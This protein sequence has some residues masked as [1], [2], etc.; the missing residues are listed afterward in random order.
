MDAVAILMPKKYVIQ[1]IEK[2]NPIKNNGKSILLVNR[3]SLRPGSRKKINRAV[4]I[5]NLKNP[6][7][8]GVADVN[9]T[10]TGTAAISER[11]ITASRPTLKSREFSDNF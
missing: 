5:L 6:I 1:W 10:N 3:F 7:V 11:A 4:A 9:F 2:S 8:K